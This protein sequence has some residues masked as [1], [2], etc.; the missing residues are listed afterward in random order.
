MIYQSLVFQKREFPNGV[1]NEDGSYTFTGI[2]ETQTIKSG[3][4][5]DTFII[6]CNGLAA[7]KTSDN[8]KLEKFVATDFSSLTMNG[9]TILSVEKPTDISVIV[10]NGVADITIQDKDKTN[11]VIAP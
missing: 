1:L 10:N 8:G 6:K 9:K 3:K 11:K 4:N 5:D 7:I 2:K